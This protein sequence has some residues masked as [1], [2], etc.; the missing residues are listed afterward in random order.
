MSVKFAN[1]SELVSRPERALF[2]GTDKAR[3]RA[4]S[5]TVARFDP[6]RRVQSY[7]N[8]TTTVR[9]LRGLANVTGNTF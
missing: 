7:I 9:S 4:E 5:V 6:S 1:A 8:C 3:L 2:A